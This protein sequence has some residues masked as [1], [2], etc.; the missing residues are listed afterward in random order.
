MGRIEFI[1]INEQLKEVYIRDDFGIYIIH[2]CVFQDMKSLE[3]ELIKLGSYYIHKS[4]ILQD[5]TLNYRPIPSCDR[6]EM[7]DDLLN[8]E[9]DY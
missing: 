1:E 9:A 6:L 3:D 7:V 2:D 4:E 8:K 5:P